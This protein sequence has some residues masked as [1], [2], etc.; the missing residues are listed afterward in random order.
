MV[1]EAKGTAEHEQTCFTEA[2][3]TEGGVC[4][5]VH[6]CRLC[7]IKE[8]QLIYGL[9]LSPQTVMNVNN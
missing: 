7:V 5:H 9:R 3:E 2:Q 1:Q 8:N 4:L 6:V